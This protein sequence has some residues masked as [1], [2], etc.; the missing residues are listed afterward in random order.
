MTVQE[1]LVEKYFEKLIPQMCV[2]Y[3]RQV[4]ALYTP[5]LYSIHKKEGEPVKQLLTLSNG[6]EYHWN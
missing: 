2:F 1:K 5:E 3:D 6:F 4:V